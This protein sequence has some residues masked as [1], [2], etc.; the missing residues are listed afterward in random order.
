M[1]EQNT[2]PA[3]ENTEALIAACVAEGGALRGQ[4]PAEEDRRVLLASHELTLTG[5]PI[6]L[7]YLARSLRRLGWQPVLISPAAGPLLDTLLQESFPVLICPSLLENDVLPRAVGLFRFVVLNTIVFAQAAAALNG[8]DTSVLWWLHEAEEVYQNQFAQSMPSR[9]FSNISAYAVSQRAQEILLRHRPGYYAG[10]LPFG[11]PDAVDQDMEPLPLSPQAKGKRIFAIIGTVERRKGQDV[12]LNAV[13]LLPEDAARQ[14]FFVFVGSVRHVDVGERVRMAAAEQADRFQY[15]PQL[16]VEKMPALYTAVDCVICASRDETGPMTMVEG[17]QFSKSLICSEHTG[18]ATLLE[19]DHAGFVYVG[20]DPAALAQCIMQVLGQSAEDESAMRERARAL[21][22]SN[23]SPVSFDRRLETEILPELLGPALLNERPNVEALL[24]R[25]AENSRKRLLHFEQLQKQELENGFTPEQEQ[26]IRK[27]QARIDQLEAQNR[28]LSESFDTIS[29]SSIWKITKPVRLTM[30]VIKRAVRPHMEMVFLRKGLY[31]LRTNGFR[32]TWQKAMQKI[33]FSGSLARIAKQAL[34]TEEELAQQRKHHFFKE[35]KFS[36]VVPL[37]NTPER[38]LRA[39]IESV[40]AQTYAGWELCMADGSDAGHAQVEQICQEYA[41]KDSRI[42]YWK[43]EKNLGISGNTNACLE[44]VA[45][46]YIG[47]FD[48]D[49]LLHPAALHEVMRAIENTGADFI[50][51]DEAV[52]E[53]PNIKTITSIH[54]KPDFAPDNLRANN[55]ICHFT[56]FKRSLLDQVGLFD[57]SFDG[58]QDHDMVLRLT[59]KA[60]RVAHIPEILYYWRA[61]A[62]SVAQNISSKQY[63]AEAGIRAVKSHI[64]RSGYSAEVYSSKGFPAIYQ[65]RY[66]IHARPKISILIPALHPQQAEACV[67]DILCKTTYPDYEII[68]GMPKDEKQFQIREKHVPVRT[69]LC[70]GTVTKAACLNRAALEAQGQYLVLL[71]ERAQ[72]VTGDW[73]E[74]M[75]MYAQRPDVGAVGAKLYD[76][77]GRIHSAGLILGAGEAHFAGSPFTGASGDA[78]GYM[79]KL[80]YAQN[81]SAVSGACMM[82]D[83]ALF[84]DFDRLDETLEAYDDVDFCLKLRRN[85]LLIVWTPYAQLRLCIKRGGKA[86]KVPAVLWTRWRE[87]LT[88]GDPYYN[89]NFRLD[90][91]SYTPKPSLSQHDAR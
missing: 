43:L 19:R 61:H 41:E 3:F 33:H 84:H 35:V 82:V 1:N 62:G 90:L 66:A 24:L 22:V 23:F 32:M 45:G 42:H 4:L 71:D 16:P 40:Q 39:M 11:I 54:F 53:S 72:I 50:Y 14:C 48:H 34:F 38:F 27:M 21:Y 88:T 2:A 31:S 81:C 91:E 46:D 67:N 83:A 80:W 52:F 25:L 65:I 59:E 7:L 69:C 78:I 89:P 37:Y 56:V 26:I 6:V 44:M 55:Y 57:P 17:C 58:S 5:A 29:N 51:T 10:V 49:D 79:G 47:L 74:Q 86:E 13:G 75:L 70:P 64:S 63:A 85:G 30:D 77:K 36:I 18:M 60:R 8:T 73:L 15:I 87:E 12:L 20:D 9:L 28:Y 68:L 76:A